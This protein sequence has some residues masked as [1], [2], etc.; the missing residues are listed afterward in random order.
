MELLLRR[1]G[2]VGIVGVVLMVGAAF[3]SIA[4]QEGQ[5]QISPYGVVILPGYSQNT[6]HLIA[7]IQTAPPSFAWFL[8]FWGL[9]IAP[10]CFLFLL[11]TL[12]EW[13]RRDE[14]PLAT[15]MQNLGLLALGC[16][17]M[18]GLIRVTIL[19]TLALPGDESPMEISLAHLMWLQLSYGLY[20][21]AYL[22]LSL[23]ALVLAFIF[24]GY[25]LWLPVGLNLLAGTFVLLVFLL[26]PYEQLNLFNLLG[27]MLPIL[28]M[29]MLSTLLL[30]QAERYARL[31]VTPAP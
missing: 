2:V 20:E 25:R 10:L 15:W 13:L 14:H 12:A 29:F 1:G 7:A 27:Y 24:R 16:W 23:H 8:P 31:V 26:S 3:L 18:A 21:G 6:D 11:N 19:P 22:L 9:I 30:L 17:I 5:S 4:V 28:R